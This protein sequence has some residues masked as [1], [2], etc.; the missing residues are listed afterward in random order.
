MARFY[1]NISVKTYGECTFGRTCICI[2][3]ILPTLGGYQCIFV[4]FSLKSSQYK[5][6]STYVTPLNIKVMP[7]L[8]D[9]RI[10]IVGPTGS[11]KSS[12]ANALLGC[13]PRAPSG[14]CMFEVSGENYSQFQ[15]Q[16]SKLPPFFGS[17]SF[18]RF[19]FLLHCPFVFLPFCSLVFFVFFSFLLFV[20]LLDITLIIYDHICPQ[21]SKVTLCVKIQKWQ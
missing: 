13:D 12:L 9:P 6:Y 19:A 8:P 14:T 15:K 4:T 21:V 20:S 18:C 7:S 1:L 10:I 17:L 5:T 3:H 2:G 16:L 11:G